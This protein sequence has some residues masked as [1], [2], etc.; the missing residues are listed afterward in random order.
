MGSLFTAAIFL[1]LLVAVV[2]WIVAV[3]V[4]IFIKQV[5]PPVALAIWTLWII[6]VFGFTLGTRLWTQLDAVV[7]ASQDIPPTR[8]PRY[9]T[10]YTLRGPDGQ[11]SRYVAGFTDATLARSMPV[12]TRLVKKR[13][14]VDY[15]RDG[16]TVDD[17][18]LPFYVPVLSIHLGCLGWSL[19]QWRKNR[20]E[21]AKWLRP[22]GPKSLHEALRR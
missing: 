3:V 15:E 21:E 5:L 6:G 7:I 1:L 2:V 22:D 11:E 9:S 17:H 16:K 10:E 18:I 12:G 20:S 13:W 4:T 19:V 8:G 14:H